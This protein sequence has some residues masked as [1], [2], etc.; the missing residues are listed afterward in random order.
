MSNPAKVNDVMKNDIDTKKLLGVYELIQQ[1]G[2]QTEE[3]KLYQ[4]IIAFSDVDGYTLYLKGNGVLMRYGFHNTY[5]LDYEH[6]NE[7][8][9]FISKI[10]QI[11]RELEQRGEG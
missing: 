8:E 5:H 2:E 11:A 7:K 1:K 10:E 4:G 9:A 6:N 3:G